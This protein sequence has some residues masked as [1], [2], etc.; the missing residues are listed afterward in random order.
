[1]KAWRIFFWVAAA[2][3]VFGGLMGWF[4]FEE[5]AHRCGLSRAELSLLRPAALPGGDHLRHRLRHGCP[6]SL[7][8]PQHRVAGPPGENRRGGDDLLGGRPGPGA[9]RSVRRA[10]AFRRRALG[11]RFRHLPCGR[12][13]ASA[14][15]PEFQRPWSPHH[16]QEDHPARP[17]SPFCSRC[18][19]LAEENPPSRSSAPRWATPSRPRS[20]PSPRI[21]RPSTRRKSRSKARSAG[22]VLWPAAGWSSSRTRP[23]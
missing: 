3:N 21:R 22:S 12:P 17:P 4:N 11:D 10:A 6:R 18:P 1:M 13:A 14:R 16:A 20:P 9:E 8:Q 15:I 5:A 23:G 7:G 2:F 19:S